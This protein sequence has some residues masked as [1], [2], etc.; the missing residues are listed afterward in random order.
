[1]YRIVNVSEGGNEILAQYF[2]VT[3]SKN[4][5]LTCH[6]KYKQGHCLHFIAI[7]SVAILQGNTIEPAAAG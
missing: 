2:R 4:I 3:C 5:N 6:C 7:F 1:M